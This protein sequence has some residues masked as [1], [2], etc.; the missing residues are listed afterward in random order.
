MESASVLVDSMTCLVR[1]S[2]P[3]TF[4]DAFRLA[5]SHLDVALCKTLVGA[6]KT[7]SGIVEGR[8]VGIGHKTSRL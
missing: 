3:T 5:R 4:A 7:A 2:M 6:K 8:Q 1:L